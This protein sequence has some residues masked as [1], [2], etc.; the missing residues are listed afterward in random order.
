[1]LTEGFFQLTLILA[2][3]LSSLVAGLLFV[4]AIVVMPGIRNLNDRE[5]IRAFQ[6]IDGVI[7][8]NQPLFILVWVGSAVALVTSAVF[9]IGQWEGLRR[10]LI[11]VAALAYILGVQLPTITI[12]IP[13]NNKLQ[14]LDVDAM[15]ETTQKNS[16][17]RVRTALEPMELNQGGH[18]EPSICPVNNSTIYTLNSAAVKSSNPN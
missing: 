7:Q 1:M 10:L 8:N 5:F 3:F 6:A 18:C 15:N 12:N 2:T 9:G 14:R 16:S 17:K 13:L 4:F 11:I